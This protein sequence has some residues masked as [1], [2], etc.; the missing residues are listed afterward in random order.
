MRR[1][2][3]PCF[4]DETQ[5]EVRTRAGD[6]HA[7]NHALLHTGSRREL[8]PACDLV[9]TMAHEQLDRGLPQAIGN[10]RRIDEIRSDGLIGGLSAV[11]IK[12]NAA[13]RAVQALMHSMDTALRIDPMQ[14]IDARPEPELE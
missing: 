6:A 8:T 2:R 11:E 7:K 9:C 1:K 10:C 12:P 3:C 5:H 13:R 4:I 14:W